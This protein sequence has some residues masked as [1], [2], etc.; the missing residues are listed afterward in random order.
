MNYNF[1]EIMTKINELNKIRYTPK[2]DQD[3]TTAN[4]Q[5]LFLLMRI[6]KALLPYNEHFYNEES[7]AYRALCDTTG[8]QWDENVWARIGG[9]TDEDGVFHQH[10]PVHYLYIDYYNKY[11]N[12]KTERNLMKKEFL[13]LITK[14]RK[15]YKNPERCY[16]REYLLNYPF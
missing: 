16:D 13:K 15:Y 8:Q 3:A 12:D 1:N 5:S 7:N 9:S 14:L 4:F 6:P 10:G 11:S 2:L